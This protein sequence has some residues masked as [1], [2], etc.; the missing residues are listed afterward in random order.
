MVKG[1][2]W[3]MSGDFH[4]PRIK[5]KSCFIVDAGVWLS[6]VCFI[7]AANMILKLTK[8]LIKRVQKSNKH[9]NKKT[10]NSECSFASNPWH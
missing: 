8:I 7:A 1:R 3:F 10:I 5:N 4:L 2:S 6:F 9:Y